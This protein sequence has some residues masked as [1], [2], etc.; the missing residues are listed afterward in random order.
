MYGTM[1]PGEIRAAEM[2]AIS[3]EY[4]RLL[5][6]RADAYARVDAAMHPANFDDRMTHAAIRRLAVAF[7]RA[8]D[9]CIDFRA[10]Y[11]HLQRPRY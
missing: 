7:D 9:A 4:Q 3:E 1:T 6:R 5:K 11:P 8:K 2:D 10:Q